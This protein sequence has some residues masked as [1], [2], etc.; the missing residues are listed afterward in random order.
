MMLA[1]VA[2]SLERA[3]IAA[4]RI[5]LHFHD[6]R[7]CALTRLSAKLSPLQ[8]AKVSGHKDLKMILNVYYRETAEDIAKL[9]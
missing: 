8:L 1:A 2:A 5:G 7:A 9:I 6:S 3:G 4:E